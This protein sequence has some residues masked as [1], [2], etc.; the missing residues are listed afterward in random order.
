VNKNVESAQFVSTK[1]HWVNFYMFYFS[2]G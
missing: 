1:F 2:A